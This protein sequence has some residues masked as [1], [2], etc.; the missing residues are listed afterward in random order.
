MIPKIIHYCWFGNNPLPD[1]MQKCIDSWRRFFPGYEIKKWNENNFDVNIMAYSQEAYKAKK[2]AF[3][4]DVARFWILYNEGGIYF[5]TDVEIVAPFEDI[6]AN[7]AFMGVESICK[8]GRL[9]N[10]NP[11]LGLGSEKGNPVLLS[12]Y[13]YYRSLNFLSK[14]G[15]VIPGTVV[16]HTTHI[17]FKQYGLKSSNE[18]QVLDGVTI[19]PM[20]YF[21]PL[22]DLTGVLKITN[23]THSI[24][25]FAKTW[26]DRPM[27]YFRIT[28][29]LHRIFGVRFFNSIKSIFG[30]E[31]TV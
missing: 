19:Y 14:E 28:R 8:P 20:D 11:G 16:T 1:S 17:L 18:I 22:D 4:S 27:W 6:I 23:N 9:P 7:G 2:Y 3:V 24:H 21:C 31:E 5:D 12:I 29:F 25:W 30:M 13:E 15:V 10:V 26:T